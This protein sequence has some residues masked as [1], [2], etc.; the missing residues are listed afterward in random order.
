[1]AASSSWSRLE[2]TV[3]ESPKIYRLADHMDIDDALAR[4]LLAGLWSWAQTHA[5]DGDL[6]GLTHNEIERGAAWKGA[7][8]ALV[9][10]MIEFGFLD[11]TPDGLV[12]HG[13]KRRLGSYG[14][15]LAKQAERLRKKDAEVQKPRGAS[16][17]AVADKSAT[18]SD[19][20]ATVADTSK[21]VADT[22][23]TVSDAP[24]VTCERVAD[25]LGFVASRGEERRGE[26]TEASAAS[27]ARL[28]RLEL[29]TLEWERENGSGGGG[30]SDSPAWS[31]PAPF[32]DAPVGSRA[33]AEPAATPEQ[34]RDA[35][36]AICGGKFA[37]AIGLT[38]HRRRWITE[39]SKP[40]HW[41]RAYFKRALE[42]RYLEATNE[43]RRYDFEWF[44]NPE[45]QIKVLEKKYETLRGDSAPPA[46]VIDMP[47][48]RPLPE[49]VP[50]DRGRLEPELARVVDGLTR[51]K[52]M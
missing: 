10:A 51:Q 18:V 22:S 12:I 5:P 21:T 28:T 52:G 50:L 34:V 41:W 9:K 39:T 33:G 19:M 49:G 48:P 38:P 23:E 11:E 27:P 8:G 13:F 16:R 37:R 40:V 35:Y 20:S 30:L 36:N 46:K 4:G 31:E 32:P 17:K 14:L 7:R 24:E 44:L 42:Q 25:C 26:E 45:N 15:A 29:D 43:K 6:R 1:M 3:R 2:S 47:K